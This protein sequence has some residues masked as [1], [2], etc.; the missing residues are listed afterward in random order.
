MHLLRG[1]APRGTQIDEFSILDKETRITDDR[2]EPKMKALRHLRQSDCR[3]MLQRNVHMRP[4]TLKLMY[5]LALPNTVCN[6]KDLK[7]S[8][9]CPLLFP[10][11]PAL[12]PR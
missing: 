6:L 10:T 11:F 8:L 4:V 9:P 7:I 12:I 1:L 2:L 5:L 3:S